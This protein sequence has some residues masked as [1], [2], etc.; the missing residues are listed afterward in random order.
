M[1]MV[2]VI[3]SVMLTAA[4]LAVLLTVFA[5]TGVGFRLVSSYEE[6]QRRFSIDAK[7][8]VVYPDLTPL[9]FEKSSVEYT[10]WPVSQTD[11]NSSAGEYFINGSSILGGKKVICT[12]SCSKSLL[13][14]ANI[15]D[16]IIYNGVE[17]GEFI[18]EFNGHY[19]DGYGVYINDCEYKVSTLLEKDRRLSESEVEKIRSEIRDVLYSFICGIVDEAQG[20]S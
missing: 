7:P 13:D 17:V 16:P 3:K 10:F 1:R 8:G 11:N 20:Q 15:H 12:F 5:C 19:S 9:N 6:I 4:F 18:E 14:C 2:R